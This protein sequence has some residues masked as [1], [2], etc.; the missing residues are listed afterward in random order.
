M[1]RHLTP[2]SPDDVPALD[3][4]DAAP[5]AWAPTGGALKEATGRLLDR[6]G[7]LQ[8]EFYADARRALLVVLQGRDASGKDGLIRKVAGA[9]RMTDIPC[10]TMGSSPG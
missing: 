1:S 9:F 4:A 3:D 10:G 5:P 6:L 8:E 7:E 2:V